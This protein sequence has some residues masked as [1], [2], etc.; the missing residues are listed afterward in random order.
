MLCILNILKKNLYKI[1]FGIVN[2][3]MEMNFFI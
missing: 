2:Y 1:N 3:L